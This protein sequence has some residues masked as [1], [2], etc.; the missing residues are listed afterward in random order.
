MRPLGCTAHG[1]P[2][3]AGNLADAGAEDGDEDANSAAVDGC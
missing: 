1:N 3:T 2:P